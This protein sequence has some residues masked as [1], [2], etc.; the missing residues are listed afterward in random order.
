MMT[1]LQTN[2]YKAVVWFTP[3]INT[4]S[5]SP[6][7]AANCE[8][9]VCLNENFGMASNYPSALASNYFVHAVNSG[10]TNVLSVS[11]WKGSGSPGRFHQPER[12]AMVP[13]AR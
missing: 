13:G 3:F 11:W 6:E 2:G 9:N 1:F 10:V 8:Y 5:D 7:C 4:S 12:G